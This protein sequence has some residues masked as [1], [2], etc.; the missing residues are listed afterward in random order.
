[1]RWPLLVDIPKVLFDYLTVPRLP[2]DGK[3]R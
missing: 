2:A 3:H 1:M